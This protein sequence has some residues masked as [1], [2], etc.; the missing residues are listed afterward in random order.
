MRN[1]GSKTAFEKLK[2]DIK[3]NG[4]HE[5]IKFVE[6]NGKRFVV[7]GHHRLRAAKELSIQN[8]PAQKVELPC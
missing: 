7:D 1:V 2:I 6:H 3:L 5:P 8:I 4:I